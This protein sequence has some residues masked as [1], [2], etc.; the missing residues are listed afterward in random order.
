VVRVLVAALP[1]LLALGSFVHLWGGL[2]PRTQEWVH[3]AASVNFAAITMILATIGVLGFF[4]LGWLILAKRPAIPWRWAAI[5]MATA[6][7]IALI[8]HTT[9]DKDAGR[10]GG[11]WNLARA[12]PTFA[13]RSPLIIGM[14]ALGGAVI[15][16]VL[17][18]L[19]PRERWVLAAALA[20]FTAAMA[21]VNQA[22]QRYYEPMVLMVYV[23]AAASPQI[24]ASPTP[25]HRPTLA[26][27]LLLCVAFIQAALTAAT[28][29]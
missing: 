5:G 24:S 15:A 21:T 13:D 3:P 16:A 17:T 2:A 7:L 1:G 6:V 9:Y 8:P 27:L 29:K 14:A 23:L 10:W 11:L 12:T 22:W 19:R 26:R 18:A 4:Y 25:P 28:L 20:A